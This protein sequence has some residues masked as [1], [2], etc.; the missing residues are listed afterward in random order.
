MR[1]V[2]NCH[3]RASYVANQLED[4]QVPS[5]LPCDYFG[6]ARCLKV[7][8]VYVSERWLFSKQTPT[9]HPK[10]LDV[11]ELWKARLLDYSSDVWIEVIGTNM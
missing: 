1:L 4:F 5:F 3:V 8:F 6:V 7:C 9:A 11:D 2:D 10:V